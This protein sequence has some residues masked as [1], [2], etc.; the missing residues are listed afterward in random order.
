MILK[1]HHTDKGLCR[2]CFTA[3]EAGN[4]CYYCI[5]EEDVVDWLTGEKGKQVKMYRCSNTSQDA[6][7][8][9][10]YRVTFAYP[11]DILIPA[12]SDYSEYAESLISRWEEERKHD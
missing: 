7:W 2:V 4:E 11:G 3:Q 6:P 8:E 9:P 5:Q 12:V 10:D 1:Y